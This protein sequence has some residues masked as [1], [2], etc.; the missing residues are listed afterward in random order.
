MASGGNPEDGLG[1]SNGVGEAGEDGIGG[2]LG[3]LPFKGINGDL[4]VHL[5]EEEAEDGEG[6][7]EDNEDVG[8]QRDEAGIPVGAV[9]VHQSPTNHHYHRLSTKVSGGGFG[10]STLSSSAGYG[11]SSSR[12]GRRSGRGCLVQR[13]RQTIHCCCLSSDSHRNQSTISLN[14]FL[15]YQNLSKLFKTGCI[16][17]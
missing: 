8:D 16:C 14:V 10:L 3:N 11:C 5:A 4:D 17:F 7:K 2:V 6:A 13:C 12:S 15:I 9:V 1:G